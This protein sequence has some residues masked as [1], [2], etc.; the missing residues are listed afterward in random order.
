MGRWHNPEAMSD[1]LMLG[2]RDGLE[3]SRPFVMELGHGESASEMDRS[4]RH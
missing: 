3:P 1:D 2:L 4:V